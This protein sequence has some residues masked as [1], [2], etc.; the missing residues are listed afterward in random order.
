MIPMI[1]PKIG[2]V[3]LAAG[4]SSR[5]QA[6]KALLPFNDEIT[7]LNKLLM[8]YLSWGCDEVVVVLNEALEKEYVCPEELK[9]HVTFVKNEHLEFERFYSVKLGFQHILTADFCFLQNVDNPFIDEEILNEIYLKRS[10]EEWISPR[11]NGKGGHPV[12]LPKMMILQLS[13]FPVND[14]NLKSVLEGWPCKKVELNRTDI[15]ININDPQDF[16]ENKSHKAE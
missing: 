3:I 16:E 1:P 12:L 6:L 13:K 5:M 14:A 8:T 9:K 11:N 4:R 15:L 10:E 7:F 2:A